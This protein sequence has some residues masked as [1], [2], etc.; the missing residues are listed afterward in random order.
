ML[1]R[2]FLARTPRLNSGLQRAEAV[3]GPGQPNRGRESIRSV[4][5]LECATKCFRAAGDLIEVLHLVTLGQFYGAWWYGL[6]CT[7]K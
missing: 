2:S 6:F 3:Q 4:F 5:A 7:D 1:Y